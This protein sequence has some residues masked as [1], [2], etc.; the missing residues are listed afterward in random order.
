MA[1]PLE[2]NPQETV[3]IPA[4]L[5]YF[6]GSAHHKIYQALCSV[7][8]SG[9]PGNDVSPWLSTI[10]IGSPT[11]EG[12]DGRY[13]FVNGTR[14]GPHDSGAQYLLQGVHTTLKMHYN[15][16]LDFLVISNSTTETI[17][18]VRRDVTMA[19]DI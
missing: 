17:V 16:T 12:A 11:A 3:S 4:S 5:V 19:T 10:C 9:E 7:W 14:L 15:D 13:R 18:R 8:E 2:Q 6:D 1:T